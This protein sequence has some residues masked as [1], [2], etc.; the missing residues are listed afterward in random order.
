MIFIFPLVLLFKI[1]VSLNH[2]TSQVSKP[3]LETSRNGYLAAISASSYSFVS[4]L[5]EFVSIMNPGITIILFS[6]LGITS[7]YSWKLSF[8]VEC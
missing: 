1:F 6:F 8:N 7:D 4:L 2:L 3:L 5:K